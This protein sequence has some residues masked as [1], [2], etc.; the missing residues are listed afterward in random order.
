VSEAGDSLGQAPDGMRARRHPWAIL[1]LWGWQT[2]LALGAS[3]PTA[4]LI[5]AVFGASPRGDAELWVPGGH[6][7]LDFLWHDAH[8]LAPV[9]STAKAVLLAAAI[10]G[11]LPMAASMFAMTDDVGERRAFVLL[12]SIS[13]ALRAMPALL[14]LLVIASAAQAGSVGLGWLVAK[15]V[16]MWFSEALGDARAQRIGLAVALVFVLAASGLGVVH[17]LARAVVVCSRTRALRALVRGARA[18]ASSPLSIWWSWAWRALAALAP[19]VAIAAVA[20]RIGGRGGFAL[21][22]LAVLHQGVVLAR[23]A[24]HLSWLAKAMRVVQRAP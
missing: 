7:L 14:L 13:R 22:A 11:L 20:S 24:L 21:V 18:F 1:G 5:H 6:A 9:T 12:R 2:A 8:A 10:L 4:S 15:G 17:D 3:W 23:V 16:D 19:V